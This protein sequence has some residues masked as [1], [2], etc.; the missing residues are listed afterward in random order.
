MVATAE[1]RLPS[2]VEAE[3]FQSQQGA[4]APRIPM[5]FASGGSCVASGWGGEAGHFLRY[6]IELPEDFPVLH[7]TLRYA[8]GNPGD[9]EISLSLDGDMGHSGNID[10]EATGDWGNRQD[11][12]KYLSMELPATKRGTHTIEIRSLKTGSNVNFDGFYL[13]SDPIATS[14]TSLQPPSGPDLIAPIGKGLEALPCRTPLAL[15]YSRRKALVAGS[16]RV[17]SFLGSVK[18]AGHGGNVA[19]P[20]LQVRLE[21]YGPWQYV[22]QRMLL[23]P[24]P[25]VVTTLKWQDVEMKQTTFAA[26]PENEGFFVRLTLKNLS[27]EAREFKLQSKVDN[28]VAELVADGT[29]LVAQSAPLLRMLP[30]D[31]GAVTTSNAPYPGPLGGGPHMDHKIVVAAGAEG[32]FDLQFLGNGASREQALNETARIWREKLAAATPCVLPDPKLQYAYDACLRQLLMMIESRPGGGRVL[33]GLEHYYGSNPYDTFQV[34]RALDAV[35]LKTDA[36]VLLRNQT[37]HL[38]EDGIFEMW[39]TGDL[40]GAGAEQWIVQGL[41]A[42]ALWEHYRLWKDEAWLREIAPTLIKAAQATLRAREAHRGEHQQGSVRVNGLLPPIIGDGGLMI[43]YHWTQNS[44]ALAGVRIAA[45]AAR[46]LHMP[47]ADKL[48]AASHEY[49]KAFDNVR[50][51]AAAADPDRMLSAYPGAEGDKRTRPLWGVVMSVTA[52]GGIAEDDPAAV[53]TLRFLQKHL[54]DGLH[55]NLG[56]SSGVWP[57]LSAEVALWHLRLGETEEAWRILGAL[58]DRASSTS[59][60]YE[61]ISHNPIQG[62]CDPADVWAAAEVVYLARQLV[63]AE[64]KK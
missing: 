26:A 36:E 47:E 56:Y 5:A 17:Q 43:G 21:G 7:V 12:W 23:S 22:E 51:Q 8:R 10:L 9:A 62:H 18:L 14:R 60:W 44:G 39:E 11:G 20:G 48:D 35:G 29:Q 61:E 13:S 41:A 38:K 50:Q 34:S 31:G 32:S 15:P 40:R 54:K 45:E 33:K 4:A 3:N 49:R 19:G 30:S 28:V 42:T 6:Q 52:F 25:S 16:G 57:Y 55:L 27:A 24:V 63:G 58:V 1:D 37:R 64:R 46:I 2:W 53:Q 59:C